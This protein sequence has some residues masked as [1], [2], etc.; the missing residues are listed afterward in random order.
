M[1]KRQQA[2]VLLMG[3][4]RRIYEYI[5]RNPKATLARINSLFANAMNHLTNL[6]MKQL[7]YSE[8][9]KEKDKI[10]NGYSVVEGIKK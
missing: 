9:V 8:R 7:I 4:E 6:K 2:V 10:V 1:N 3:D 5:E